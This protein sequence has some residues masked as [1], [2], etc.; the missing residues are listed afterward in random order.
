MKGGG[1]NISGCDAQGAES[2]YRRAFS[3]STND[4]SGDNQPFRSA[5]VVDGRNVSEAE[6]AGLVD[7]CY[8]SVRLLR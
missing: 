7:I 3:G 8:V 6:I 5:S 2:V 4:Y 1:L